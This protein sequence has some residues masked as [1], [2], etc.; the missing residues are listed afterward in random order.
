MLLIKELQIVCH[1][2]SQTAIMACEC[3]KC[4]IN[5]DNPSVTYHNSLI[6]KPNLI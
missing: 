3:S 1:I 6:N 4:L 2:G 5:N